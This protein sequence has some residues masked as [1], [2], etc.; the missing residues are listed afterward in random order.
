MGKDKVENE[1]LI[2]HGFPEDVWFH[3]DKLSSAHVYLRMPESMEWT[4]IPDGLLEECSQLVKANSIE[5]NKKNNITIIYTPHANVKKTG[6]MAVGA[7]SFHNDRLVKRFHVKERKNE[8]V[9]RLNKTK[10]ERE[11]DFEAER[12]ERERAAGR[13]KKEHALQQKKETLEAKRQYKEQA[14]AKDYSYCA[15]SVTHAVFSDEAIAEAQREKQRQARIHAAQ[16]QTAGEATKSDEED[17]YESDDSF[18]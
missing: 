7:V 11:V 18:M 9:N 8:I 15:C 2:R 3:V 5:G 4:A 14:A 13:K 1:D 17:V 16:K 12:Q 6:D 10:E